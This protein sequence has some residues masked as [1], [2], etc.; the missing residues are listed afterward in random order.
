MTFGARLGIKNSAGEIQIDQEF[1]TLEVFD[2]GVFTSAGG[3]Y[4]ALH[5]LTFS[6][7]D[8]PMVFIQMAVDTRYFFGP[9]TATTFWCSSN[10]ASGATF[11]YK[12]C[13]FR[14]SPQALP[15]GFGFKVNQPALPDAAF[16]SPREYIRII[17]ALQTVDSF[18]ASPLRSGDSYT[19]STAGD[20]SINWRQYNHPTKPISTSAFWHAAMTGLG[21]RP[22]SDNSTPYVLERKSSTRYELRSDGVVSKSNREAMGLP[23]P[24]GVAWWANHL[25]AA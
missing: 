7:I 23:D 16:A 20:G 22:G 24:T 10:H 6:G 2:E 5:T 19:F 17:D 15:T 14:P 1:L 25:I 12:L 18:D 4:D 3:G 9:T 8:S 21:P 13:G 11:A